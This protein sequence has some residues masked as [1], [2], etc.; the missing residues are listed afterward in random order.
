MNAT[1]YQHA[2]YDRYFTLLDTD[3]SNSIE[4]SDFCRAADFIRKEN[5]WDENHPRY[6]GLVGA[7]TTFWD[8]LRTRVDTDGNGRVDRKEWSDFHV[9]LAADVERLG[10][11]PAWALNV[12]HGF[13]RVL[14]VDS[15]GTISVA[16][17]RTWLRSLGAEVDFD[18]AFQHLDL[19]RDGHIDIDE[20]EELFAQWVLSDNPGDPGNWLVTGQN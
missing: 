20:T 11:V 15:D 17:Y 10:K 8:E 16:E 14:D 6:L 18:A 1:D 13:H 4:W 2:K 12:V 19:N 5:G 7:L 9:S 3:R